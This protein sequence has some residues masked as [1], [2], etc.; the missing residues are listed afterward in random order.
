VLAAVIVFWSLALQGRFWY[1]VLVLFAVAMANASM[2]YL[3][4]SIPNDP[5]NSREFIILLMLPQILFAGFYV[6][7]QSLP[8]WVQWASYAMPSFY[9]FRLALADE[10]AVCM[11]FEGMDQDVI[12]CIE[13]GSNALS[14]AFQGGGGLES[15]YSDASSYVLSEVGVFEGQEDSIE[16]LRFAD[17]S[18]SPTTFFHDKCVVDGSL[19]VWHKSSGPDKCELMFVTT[20]QF[21]INPNYATGK[22]KE[23]PVFNSIQ[24]L[25]VEFE[26]DDDLQGITVKQNSLYFPQ[27]LFSS[28]IEEYQNSYDHA[29]TICEILEENCPSSWKKD[30]FVDRADCIATMG[31]LPVT[32]KNDRGEFVI[33]SNSTACRVVHATLAR[34]N[35]K[36]CPH[37]SFIPE[38][39]ADG[40]V[41]CSESNNFSATDRFD[42]QDLAIFQLAATENGMNSTRQLRSVYDDPSF[43]SLS[44]RAKCSEGLVGGVSGSLRNLELPKNYFCAQ[45]LQSQGATGEYDMLYWGVLIGL[46]VVI[47]GISL[48]VMSSKANTFKKIKDIGVVGP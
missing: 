14:S 38:T 34:E 13:S 17:S 41:V 30:G 29:E 44:D 32:E 48:C 31:T 47:R 39:D 8:V 22:A 43:G 25:I 40:Y 1:L 7:T 28:M 11:Q 5:R 12:R 37:I 3:L 46:Y 35:D 2:A 20:E 33:D 15:L 10:F 26:P 24:G 42:D 4:G 36:H 23:M 19:S 6:D 27:A 18:F 45:Y 21:N 9:A 16:Y